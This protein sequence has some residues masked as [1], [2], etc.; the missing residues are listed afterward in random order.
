MKITINYYVTEHYHSQN[1]YLQNKNYKHYHLKFI[2]LYC[3]CE[4]YNVITLLK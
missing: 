3:V 4:I 1:L 2:F